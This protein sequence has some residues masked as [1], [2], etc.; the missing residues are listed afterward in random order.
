[1]TAKVALL[2]ILSMTVACVH[3]SAHGPW[4][5]VSKRQLGRV[6][7][8]T[9]IPYAF[10]IPSWWIPARATEVLLFV[11][12]QWGN[13]SP[14]ESSHIEIYTRRNG[15]HYSKYISMHTFEQSA[16]STNSDNIWLPL[17][18]SRETVYVKTPRVHNGGPHFGLTIDVIGYR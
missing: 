4:T 18:T 11:D 1:M 10:H 6:N 12:V 17:F 14:D 16:W 2:V 15:V 9:T 13:S 3:V 7:L 8:R 5:P